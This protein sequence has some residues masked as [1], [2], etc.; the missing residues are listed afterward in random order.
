EAGR[1]LA[2]ASVGQIRYFEDRRVTLFNAADP[3]LDDSASSLVGELSVNLGEHWRAGSYLEW[4]TTTNE[5]DV[6]NFQ[7]QFQSDINRILNLGYRLREMPGPAMLNGV[8]RRIDQTDI[9]GI[10][11]LND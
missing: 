3:Q 6:A 5:L 10:W 8:K 2:R 7:F 4:N 11:P 1:E 9:S